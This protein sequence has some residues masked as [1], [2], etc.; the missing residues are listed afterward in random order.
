M[1]FQES[2]QKL[3]EVWQRTNSTGPNMVGNEL[4]DSHKGIMCSKLVY[5]LTIIHHLLLDI[6][7]LD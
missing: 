1:K 7:H 2:E 5:N 4:I 6:L 3:M